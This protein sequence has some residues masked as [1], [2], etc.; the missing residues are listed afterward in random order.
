MW[1]IF[2]LV[3]FLSNM[4]NPKLHNSL[5]NF[6]LEAQKICLNWSQTNAKNQDIID[7]FICG[8]NNTLENQS[9][10]FQKT[11][12]IHLFVISGSHF[13]VLNF[14]LS[15]LRIPLF[16]RLILLFVFCIF[17]GGAPPAMRAF[18]SILFFSGAFKYSKQIP[19]DLKT[20]IVGLLC[21]TLF[22]GWYKS[23]SL[24]LSW[25]AALALS[26]NFVLYKKSRINQIIFTQ[27]IVFLFMSIPLSYFSSIQPISI[28]FNLIFAHF[29]GSF[30]F[31]LALVCVFF[32]PLTYLFDLT[33][34]G[35]V[36]IIRPYAQEL[37]TYHPRIHFD[38][39]YLWIILLILHYSIHLFRV[40]YKQQRSFSK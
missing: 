36:F 26:F 1:F 30:L 18:L 37:G 27:V 39:F 10:I 4:T 14:I 15:F 38:I 9:L 2:F 24:I 8:K 25:Y 28:V 3:F 32:H 40:Q 29:L 6:S 21:L 31:P 33:F 23:I 16:I 11:S 19:Q 34:D 22:P 7:A 17:S 20:L 35:V 5:T 12:L 13:L